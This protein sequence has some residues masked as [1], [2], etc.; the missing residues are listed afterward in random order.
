LVPMLAAAKCD[1]LHGPVMLARSELLE[2]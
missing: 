1:P 2:P